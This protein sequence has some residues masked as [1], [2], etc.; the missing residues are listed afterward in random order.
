MVGTGADGPRRHVFTCSRASASF[1]AGVNAALSFFVVVDDADADAP[2]AAAAAAGVWAAGAPAVWPGSVLAVPSPPTGNASTA[3]WC[4]LAKSP[5][6]PPAPPSSSSS[7]SPVICKRTRSAYSPLRA[8]SS[9][10][11]PSSAMTPSDTTAILSAVRMVE[12]RWAMTMVVCALDRDNASMLCC[13]TRSDDASKALVAS[14]SSSTAGRLTNARAM[15]M[16]CFCPP[17]MATPLLPTS[18]SYPWGNPMM[19]SCAF[20]CKQH[21]M[22]KGDVV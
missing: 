12:R 1:S 18:V 8:S 2:A 4:R 20:A 7:S 19:K 21:Y 9:E 5:P 6:C 22:E 17:D 10:W 13:T 14:S 16:R 15:A 3:T 11:L